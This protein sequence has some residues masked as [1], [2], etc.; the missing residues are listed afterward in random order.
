MADTADTTTEKRIKKK[1]GKKRS[2]G[3]TSSPDADAERL[4]SAG[5]ALETP[6]ADRDADDAE[7]GLDE[8]QDLSS[9]VKRFRMDK[10]STVLVNQASTI[11][12]LENIDNKKTIKKRLVWSGAHKVSEGRYGVVEARRILSK[13]SIK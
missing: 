6:I 7:D 3:S 5:S 8:E 1:G 10:G 9:A 4:S 12:F 2:E 11:Q 13:T